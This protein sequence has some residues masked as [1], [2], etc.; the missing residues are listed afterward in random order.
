MDSIDTA[1]SLEAKCQTKYDLAICVSRLALSAADRMTADQLIDNTQVCR[2]IMSLLSPG[3]GQGDSR[4]IGV[5]WFSSIQSRLAA[6]AKSQFEQDCSRFRPID[7]TPRLRLDD[8]NLIAEVQATK[9][10]M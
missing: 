8:H 4:L 1:N 3:A 2:L 5:G 9:D 10:F 6:P 7:F